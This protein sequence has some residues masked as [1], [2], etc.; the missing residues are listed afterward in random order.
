[1]SEGSIWLSECE[2][3]QIC[4]SDFSIL[5]HIHLLWSDMITHLKLCPP[6]EWR[7]SI[8]SLSALVFCLYQLLRETSAS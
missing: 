8:L 7:S 6:D 5:I 1:M 2:H 3:H 4:A